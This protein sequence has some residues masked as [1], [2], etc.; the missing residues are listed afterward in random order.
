MKTNNN[1]QWALEFKLP[2]V[3]KR[4]GASF[5]LCFEHHITKELFL[6]IKKDRGKRKKIKR[7]SKTLN[8]LP[9]VPDK[10]QSHLL[11]PFPV[12]LEC[13]YQQFSDLQRET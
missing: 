10:L 11:P 8:D 1:E 4:W 9:F 7:V 6:K 13:D 12:L 2:D 5:Q 3:L